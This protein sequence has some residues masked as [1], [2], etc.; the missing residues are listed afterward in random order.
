MDRG[1]P[2]KNMGPVDI[3]AVGTLNEHQ[4]NQTFGVVLKDSNWIVH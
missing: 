4:M 1:T 3:P 2:R